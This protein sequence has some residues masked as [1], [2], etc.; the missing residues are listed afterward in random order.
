M[1]ATDVRR[2]RDAYRHAPHE[3]ETRSKEL[4]RSPR[5]MGRESSGTTRAF[6]GTRRVGNEPSRLLCENVRSI[7]AT[8]RLVLDVTQSRTENIKREEER[9]RFF[10]LWFLET[11]NTFENVRECIFEKRGKCAFTR[12]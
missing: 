12:L 9:R 1:I 2:H 5:A 11:R 6:R 10:R 4:S 8:A 7:V 3:Y